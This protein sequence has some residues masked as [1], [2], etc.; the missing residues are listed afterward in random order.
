MQGQYV[1][2]KTIFESKIGDEVVMLDTESGFYFGLNSVASDIWSLLQQPI[3]LDEIVQE[4]LEQYAVDP[5]VCTDDTRVLLEQMLD[6]KIITL[7]T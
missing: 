6:K 3:S 2:C 7:A 1:Q 5:Q 4:L